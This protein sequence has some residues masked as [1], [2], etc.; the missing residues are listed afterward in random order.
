MEGKDLCGQPGEHSEGDLHYR[1]NFNRKSLDSLSS[2][3]W[4]TVWSFS[5]IPDNCQVE[6]P[7][8]QNPGTRYQ[9]LGQVELNRWAISDPLQFWC[10]PSS[11]VQ[12]TRATQPQKQVTWYWYRY[13]RRPKTTSAVLLLGCKS[14]GRPT[15]ATQLKPNIG[16]CSCVLTAS[17]RRPRAWLASVILKG[18]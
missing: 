1:Y 3:W 6:V 4:S 13:T 9:V 5:Q 15:R 12:P 2:S 14:Y 7:G 16:Y 10:A 8:T 18:I 17:K 11:Y